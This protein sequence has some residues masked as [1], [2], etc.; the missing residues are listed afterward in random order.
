MFTS[1]ALTMSGCY[2]VG[3]GLGL[4]YLS[5]ALFLFTATG[6][7]VA[8]AIFYKGDNIG[9]GEPMKEIHPTLGE[10][11]DYDCANADVLLTRMSVKDGRIV[12]P[13]GMSYRVLI[14]PDGQPM[15]L[16]ALR[17]VAKLVEAGATVVG[18]P[19]TG[20]AGLPVDSDEEQQFEALVT[21]FWGGDRQT[22]V[23]TKRQIGAE[24]VITG[25]SARETLLGAGTP[26]DFEQTGVS[27][28]GVIHWIHRRTADADIYFIAS[29]WRPVEKLECVFRVAGKQPELWD[30]V[31]GLIREAVAFRQDG[32]RTT[33][34]LEFGPCG[35]IFVVFRRPI[36]SAA[37]GNATA[38]SPEN[39]KVELTLSG[40]WEV[41]FD[42][43]W[44]GPEKVSFDELVD[45]T[46]RPETGIKYYSGTAVYRKN[47][48]LARAPYPSARLLLD[49]GELHE[50]GAVRLNG[51]DLGVVWTKPARLDITDTLKASGNSLEIT[52]VNLWPNR[53]IGDAGLPVESRF[54]ETNVH[55]FST[56]S[57]L[58]ASGLLGPVKV[59]SVE[60]L[61]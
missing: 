10:G 19:P 4:Q 56:H 47:F 1:P 25:Q 40:S 44:G 60:E 36:S 5:G 29:Q 55:K 7:V 51:R 42:P 61:G 21:Q 22:F 49:L 32:G 8:D 45:W 16:D 9:A 24:L 3:A 53:L 35:S 39:E 41:N 18:P 12:L 50:V 28:S 26:P 23:P 58:L 2:L 14:L 33:I 34:P 54:T 15:A 31:T 59:L 6:K 43:R 38:N 27:A 17:K 30:P 57:P 20:L 46:T 52:I 13:D 37:N 48:D 11:Y